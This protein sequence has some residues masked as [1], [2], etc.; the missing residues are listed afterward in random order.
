MAKGEANTGEGRSTP[1][2]DTWEDDVKTPT[3]VLV[4]ES[5]TIEIGCGRVDV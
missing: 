5:V 4:G 2:N 1:L 3:V